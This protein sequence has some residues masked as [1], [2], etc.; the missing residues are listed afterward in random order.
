STCPK[1]RRLIFTQKIYLHY[2]LPFSNRRTHVILHNFFITIA[3]K[4]RFRTIPQA[5]RALS[6]QL[7]KVFSFFV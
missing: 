4:L 3:R 1:N 2:L 5:Q 7:H 6:N